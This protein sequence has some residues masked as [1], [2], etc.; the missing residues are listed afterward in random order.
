MF[1]PLNFTQPC[2]SMARPCES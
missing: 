2:G 1:D